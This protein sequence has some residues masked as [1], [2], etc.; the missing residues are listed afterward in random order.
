MGT[1]VD[2][3]GLH[4]R[5][6]AKTV[7]LAEQMEG[8]DQAVRDQ[9]VKTKEKFDL[10]FGILSELA[11]RQTQLEDS[12]R[13][14]QQGVQWNQ[15]QNQQNSNG[16]YMVMNGGQMGNFQ[17]MPSDGGAFQQ[18]VNGYAAAHYE[19]D[20]GQFQ[21]GNQMFQGAVCAGVLVQQMPQQNQKQER[22]VQGFFR[23]QEEGVPAKDIYNTVS[24]FSNQQSLEDSS[25]SNEKGE[26]GGGRY[27]SSGSGFTLTSNK[28]KPAERTE[29]GKGA[30]DSRR[31]YDRSN[32]DRGGDR[33]GGR[34]DRGQQ[35]WNSW[36]DRD[37]DRNSGWGKGRGDEKGWGDRD[38]GGSSRDNWRDEKD[39]S[40][41]GGK[42]GGKDRGDWRSQQATLE[43]RRNWKDEDDDDESVEP[44]MD[45]EKRQ[46]KKR[47]YF[48]FQSNVM[49][50][51]MGGM[52][53][54]DRGAMRWCKWME[55]EVAKRKSEVRE[56]RGSNNEPRIFCRTLKLSD[57]D[58]GDDA[59]A[60]VVKM[61][62]ASGLKVERL[63]IH[64][65][66]LTDSSFDDI[67]KLLSGDDPVKEMHMSH[68]RFTDEGLKSLLEKLSV[69]K[70]YPCGRDKNV[71]LWLRIEQNPIQNMQAI[72]EDTEKSTGLKLCLVDP[73]IASRRQEK[74]RTGGACGPRWCKRH[75]AADIHVVFQND[76]RHQRED[77]RD[78]R[79]ERRNRDRKGDAET[80]SKYRPKSR[81]D[82]QQ[83]EGSEGGAAA[84]SSAIAPDQDYDD[85][86][87]DQSDKDY[88]YEDIEDN[89]DIE[90]HK[91]PDEPYS[92]RE[93]IH[94]TPEKSDN[95]EEEE[96]EGR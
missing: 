75:D 54:G 46:W 25:Q 74:Q 15:D 5:L 27:G 55:E 45:K 69:S 64:S 83:V 37:R 34:W 42:S 1:A 73:H 66:R 4:W 67:H 32:D 60:E 71:P 85:N 68:N 49:E 82:D 93:P 72:I 89:E 95:D 81:P 17:M 65:N 21:S 8:M 43:K 88:Q 78:R 52:K 9:N 56:R 47:V 96:R 20:G 53:L 22:M 24:N 36:G 86:D 31:E 26:K 44:D 57:N 80:Q 23:A 18:A 51:D 3:Q 33:S 39:W 58:L 94:D 14:M 12:V 63:K 6:Q 35:D 92:A 11:N 40:S 28:G 61:L 16:G 79:E 38:R 30:L 2:D 77:W 10:I 19:Q 59:C 62:V 76:T 48:D 70:A 41:R 13:T 84:A 50:I 87:S 29:R 7:E 91:A 90:D